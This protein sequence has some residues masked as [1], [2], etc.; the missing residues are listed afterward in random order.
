DDPVFG[1]WCELNGLDDDA[2]FPNRA[3]PILARWRATAAGVVRGK[4]NPLVQAALKKCRL[5][6]RNDVAKLYGDLLRTVY[7]KSRLTPVADSTEPAARAQLLAL[8]VGPA[9]PCDFPKSQTRDYMS[10]TEKD[11]F[12]G[13]MVEL[14]R[15]AVKAANAPA[16]AMVL[17]DT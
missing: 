8:V 14:D 15:M 9:S 12:G 5:A 11:S 7:E 1:P 4:L 16:R 6:C 2:D 10:R 3:A 13:R 17:Y